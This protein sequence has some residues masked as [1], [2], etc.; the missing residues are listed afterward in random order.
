VIARAPVPPAWVA[1]ADA[2]AKPASPVA[3]VA[4]LRRGGQPAGIA[5]AVLAVDPPD[6]AAAA[7]V[8]EAVIAHRIAASQTKS[9]FIFPATTQS[10]GLLVLPEYPVNRTVSP[11]GS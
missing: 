8:A 2:A 3:E 10:L 4:L 1:A 5:A 9:R 7:V 6:T 11:S